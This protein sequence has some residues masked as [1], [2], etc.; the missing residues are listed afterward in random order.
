[1]SYYDGSNWFNDTVI[2]TVLPPTVDYLQ[3]TDIPNGV[4][5]P[6]R[7]VAVGDV[8]WGNASLYN[9]TFGFLFTVSAN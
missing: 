4:P 5:L 7:A 1:M 2:Y 8:F 3:I 9:N 6:N